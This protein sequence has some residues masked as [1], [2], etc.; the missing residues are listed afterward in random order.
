MDDGYTV[1]TTAAESAETGG[2]DTLQAL[3]DAD[4]FLVADNWGDL[5]GGADGLFDHDT[6]ILSRLVMTVGLARPSRLSSGV[7]PGQCL[8]HLPHDQPAPAPDGRAVGAGGGA[9]YRAAALPVGP[10]DVRAGADGQP[11]GRGR[12]AAAG[13][14]LRGRFRRHLPGARDAAGQAR[15]RRGPDPR[16]PAGHVPLHGPGRGG[17]DQLPRLL[18]AAGAADAGRGPSSCSAC[19]WA[20]SWTSISSAVADACRA[21]D[22]QRWRDAAR[23][24]PGWPCGAAS[25]RRLAERAAQSALQ[26]V[27][28]PVAGRH[29]AADHRPADRALSLCGDRR[30]SRRRSGGTG[31]SAPGRC[32]GSIRR[33][34]RG[35]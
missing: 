11:R 33:W 32:C 24:R 26:P 34:P 4:T 1:Q 13:L 30:G 17:A 20:E 9:A 14:R 35:C 31:S 5:K 10:A 19:R 25:A 21:P 15:D 29:R 23:C 2:L 7:Q 8:L 6:R 27:A 22:A 12:P 16:R 28:G 3:K 18:G